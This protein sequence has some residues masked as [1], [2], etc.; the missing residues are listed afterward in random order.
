MRQKDA[1]NVHLSW[2]DNFKLAKMRG[3]QNYPTKTWV[4]SQLQ[5]QS[6]SQNHKHSSLG[7]Q[8]L[9]NRYVCGEGGE[10]LL[11]KLNTHNS[12]SVINSSPEVLVIPSLAQ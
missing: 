9:T 7:L 2:P 4:Q 12:D 6:H 10:W 5:V 8:Y 1:Q 3:P 11:L